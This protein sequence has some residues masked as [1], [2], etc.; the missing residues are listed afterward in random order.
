VY[1]SGSQSRRGASPRTAE[2]PRARTRTTC[3][4]RPVAPVALFSSRWREP[5]HDRRGATIQ[6]PLHTP[7]LAPA[8]ERVGGRAGS[9]VHRVGFRGS[10][11]TQISTYKRNRQPCRRTVP[12]RAPRFRRLSFDRPWWVQHFIT[13]ILVTDHRLIAH[14]HR[15]P[16]REPPANAQLLTPHQAAEEKDTGDYKEE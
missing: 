1:Y 9:T 15:C 16:L 4:L 6:I 13:H 8:G 11:A 3:E 7:I 12:I 2:T 10:S 14:C 5:H